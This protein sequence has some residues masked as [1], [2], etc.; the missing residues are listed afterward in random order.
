M[1]KRNLLYSCGALGAVLLP[2][3]TCR[4]LPALNSTGRLAAGCTGVCGCCGGS[5][6][7]VF[8]T[9][10]FLGFCAFHSRKAE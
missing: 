5:C 6:A 9:L 3:A 2:Q 1:K 7:G 10:L 4:I 8:G